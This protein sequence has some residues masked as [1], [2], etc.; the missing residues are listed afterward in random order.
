MDYFSFNLH[1]FKSFS[2]SF[3]WNLHIHMFCNYNIV[4]RY[5]SQQTAVTKMWMEF[6]CACVENNLPIHCKYPVFIVFITDSNLHLDLFVYV[7][8]CNKDKRR[9]DGSSWPMCLD[10]VISCEFGAY[11]LAV[12]S[13]LQRTAHFLLA[14]IYHTCNVTYT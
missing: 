14:H 12:K 9:N 13:L 3:N 1:R 10:R 4:M 5:N 11:R 2:D 7:W 6:T 8:F